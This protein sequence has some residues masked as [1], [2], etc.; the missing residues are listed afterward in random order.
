MILGES[1]ATVAAL[2]I[3]ANQAVQDVPYEVVRERL[4]KQGQVL[5]YKSVDRQG[6]DPKKLEGIVV[7]DEAAKQTG[8][9]V[10]SQSAESWV[11]QHY[12]HD[13]NQK[14]SVATIRFETKIPATGLYQVAVAY[15]PNDNRASN[16]LVQVTHGE[17]TEAIRI[18]QRKSPGPRGMKVIGTYHFEEGEMATVTISNEATDGY[19][20]ADA[21]QWLGIQ[22]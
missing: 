9:W 6:I 1:A 19:V 18:D 17:Q 12:L 8:H 14:D 22:E 4:L 11:G 2:A 15:P 13:S 5:E 3:D 21:V 7:D 20:I 10:P 16:A